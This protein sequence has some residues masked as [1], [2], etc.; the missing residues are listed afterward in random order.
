MS[1]WIKQKVFCTVWAIHFSSVSPPLL[2][3]F[4]HLAMGYGEPAWVVH[5]CFP[6]PFR[7]AGRTGVLFAQTGQKIFAKDPADISPETETTRGTDLKGRKPTPNSAAFRTLQLTKANSSNG[8]TLPLRSKLDWHDRRAWNR[9]SN[10][11]KICRAM[12]Y[13]IPDTQKQT[14]FLGGR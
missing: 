13:E 4:W 11:N 7:A 14:R 3:A 1:L 2:F 10:N 9:G 8:P 6:P 12:F 5:L